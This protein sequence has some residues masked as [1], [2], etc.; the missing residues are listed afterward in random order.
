[1]ARN[2]DHETENAARIRPSLSLE[3]PVRTLK[4]AAMAWSSAAIEVDACRKDVQP[5]AHAA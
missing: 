2:T 5:V 4:E 3:S 1:M